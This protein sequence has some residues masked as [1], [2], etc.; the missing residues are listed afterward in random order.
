MKDTLYQVSLLQGLM[1]GD[2]Y[3]SISVKELKE[4][5]DIGIGTFEGVNG[6]LVMLGGVVYQA[7][8][9]DEVKIAADDV[10]VPFANVAKFSQNSSCELNN[11]AN[12]DVLIKELEK[13]ISKSGKN[14]FYFVQ[15]SV[16][17]AA[18]CYRSEE[19]Q[20]EPYL[21]LA[22]ALKRSERDFCVNSADGDI[23]ALFTPS[24]MNTLNIS[25]WHFHFISKDKKHGGHATHISFKKAVA[26]ICALSQFH[27]FLPHSKYFEQL[28]FK[29]DL[30]KEIRE[31]EK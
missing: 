24:F 17:N 10:K 16:E 23:V 26:R 28:N 27:M 14:H 31:V 9:N 6:E 21:P 25:G 20:S 1:Q 12:S 2:F 15:I 18:I 13:N 5:G 22:A 30:N 29:K 4:L 11:I 7:L 19:A 3:G 8:G